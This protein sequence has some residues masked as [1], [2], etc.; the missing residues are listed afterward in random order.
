M[1]APSTE[2]EAKSIPDSW[3][4][5]A[6][7]LAE[8]Y[9]SGTTSMFC[10]HGNTHD[11]V[12]AGSGGASEEGP[13]KFVPLAEFVAGS[14]F[15]RWDLVLYYDLSSGLRVIAG[16]DGERHR[17]MAALVGRRIGALDSIGKD[18]SAVF[19]VLDRF[20]DKN[21][22]AEGPNRLSVAIIFGHASFLAR[23]GDHS[24]KASTHLVT[25]LNWASSP[26]VK[27]LNTAFVLI[28]S[29][30]SD[31]AERLVGN[32]HVAALEVT[33]P[34][35]PTRRAYLEALIGAREVASFSDYGLAQLAELTAGISLTDLR[36]LVTSAIESGRRLDG[37]RFSELKKTLIER[38][39]AGLLEFIEPRWGL[40]MVIGHEA[41]KQ[42][43]K[44]DAALI[45]RGALDSV[46]MGYLLCGPVG[47]GKSFLAQCAAGTMGMPCIKLKNFR[48]K[49]VGETESNLERVLGVLRSMGPVLVIVDEAD[50]MLGDRGSS[51]DAGVSGRIFGMIA[52]Q[53]GDTRYRGK[54]LWMLMTT[55]P[56][57]LPIDLKR[58]GRAEVHIPLF[59]PTVDEELRQMFVVLARKV[60]ASIDA[61]DVPAVGDD[62]RGHLSGADIEGIVGRAWRR[63]LLAGAD[64]ITAEAAR[65]ALDGFMPMA[66][67][68]ERELQTLAAIVECTDREFLTPAI[69]AKIAELGGRGRVQERLNQLQAV[70]DG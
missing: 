42:R 55:R 63:S 34:D 53:M 56:D 6:R 58:Q 68:L 48:S 26:Y 21:V 20:I 18:P 10:L 24:L 67:S 4:E 19:H 30:L 13:A 35:L 43:L 25:L 62:K 12:R 39:A 40:D 49:F 29:A 61:A 15:G 70:V 59:Y 7:R 69:E 37:A 33:L 66:Q 22:M 31:V 60:G 51:G 1:S 57:Y 2:P 64:R 11:L 47:T 32:P 8:L 54:I 44:D 36:V 16:T 41:A 3:P 50:A 65:E 52:Q 23:R 45:A 17:K 5:W 46:P 38:Q 28:D 14:L 27:R 9:F